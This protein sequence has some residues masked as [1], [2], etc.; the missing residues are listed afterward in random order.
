MSEN[1]PIERLIWPDDSYVGIGSTFGKNQ[2]IVS[3]IIPIVKDGG[4]GPAVWFEIDS[5]THGNLGEVNAN[6]LSAIVYG[7]GL[8]DA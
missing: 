8:A 3:F 2:R 4:L 7:E 5:A 1:K 6:F